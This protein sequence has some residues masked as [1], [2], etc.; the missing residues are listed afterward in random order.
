MDTTGQ[1]ETS[2]IVPQHRV[3]MK[4]DY[5]RVAV[6]GQ[7]QANEPQITLIRDGDTVKAIEVICTCGQRIRLNC[8]F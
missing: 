1:N 5:T 6:P 3:H 8:V 4:H 2:R 7:D